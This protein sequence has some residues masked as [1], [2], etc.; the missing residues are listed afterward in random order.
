MSLTSPRLALH[1]CNTTPRDRPPLQST[2]YFASERGHSGQCNLSSLALCPFVIAFA[3]PAFSERL[4]L[5]LLVS[6]RSSSL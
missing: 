2:F 3:L 4:H 1:A 6:E 5:Q